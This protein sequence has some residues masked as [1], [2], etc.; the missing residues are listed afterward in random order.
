MAAIAYSVSW[1]LCRHQT[2]CDLSDPGWQWHQLCSIHHTHLLPGEMRWYD[3]EASAV[4]KLF[5]MFA[6][7][8]YNFL[9]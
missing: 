2:E 6:E 4:A 3:K 9:L 8:F 7:F 5:V 1:A